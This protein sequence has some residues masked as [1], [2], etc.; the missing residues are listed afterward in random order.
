M[1]KYRKT[2]ILTSFFSKQEPMS[3]LETA[4]AIEAIRKK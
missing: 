2:H 4:E 1:D 3:A